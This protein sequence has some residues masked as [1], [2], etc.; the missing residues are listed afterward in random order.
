MKSRPIVTVAELEPARKRLEEIVFGRVERARSCDREA[1]RF[2]DR[3]AARV[4]TFVDPCRILL[5]ARRRSSHDGA[6]CDPGPPERWIFDV[7]FGTGFRGLFAIE[8]SE[9]DLGG[10]PF[11]ISARSIVSDEEAR[12]VAALLPPAFFEVC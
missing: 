9:R 5:E 12:E 3:T 2:P 10:R 1:V 8:A 11:E 6:S 7:F 4:V